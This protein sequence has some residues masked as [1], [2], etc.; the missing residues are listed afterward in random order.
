MDKQ[1][2]TQ[3]T[4]QN[5][6]H[7]LDIA[8]TAS[9][10]GSIGGSIASIVF[11]EMFMASI[12]LSLC[13]ALNLA[14]RKR[15][16]SLTRTE[17]KTAIAE[18]AQQNQD[19]NN[20]LSEQLAK[21]QQSSNNQLEN[22]QTDLS[23]QINELH[24]DLNKRAQELQTQED[25]LA[26][27]LEYLN[28]IE[29]STRGIQSSPNSA[30]LYCQRGVNYQQMGKKERAIEDYTKVIEID[31][32]S[33][34]AHHYRGV[35]NSELGNRKAAVEDLRKAAKFYFE[36]GDL[37]S[38]QK[39]RNMSQALHELNYTSKEQNSERVLAN[40]LFS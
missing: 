32:S 26:T 3:S 19:N 15:L 5:N 13:V 29:S 8:E 6:S 2:E 12:P 23:Q 24:T 34:L 25:E 16:L 22:V 27:K 10:I 40:S 39:T 7:W 9:V 37:D 35:V 28:Q 11:K 4:P 18:L 17:T 36:Q 33:A 14:N 21:F 1:L 38:Y 30:E 31:P 20:N